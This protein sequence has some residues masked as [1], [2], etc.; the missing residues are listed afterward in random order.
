M[1]VSKRIARAPY[2]AEHGLNVL[3]LGRFRELSETTFE[4][5]ACPKFKALAKKHGGYTKIKPFTEAQADAFLA[6]SWE[7]TK[8]AWAKSAKP[9]AK[10]RKVSK[11]K[12]AKATRPALLDALT[13]DE[14]KVLKAVIAKL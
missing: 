1:R 12:A 4:R 3:R 6:E 13:L 14:L 5:N 9:K 11:A 7:R 8:A 2:N 10:A